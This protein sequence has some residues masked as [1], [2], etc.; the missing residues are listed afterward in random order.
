MGLRI[1]EFFGYAQRDQSATALE[2]R[3][4]FRCPFSG[5]RCRKTLDQGRLISGVCTVKQ[6]TRADP[7]ICCPI[8]LYD[9]LRQI[10]VDV[11]TQVFGPGVRVVSPDELATVPIDAT[12][13]IAFGKGSGGEL[14]LPRVE[15]RGG[16]FVDWVLA[17]VD[18]ERRLK[19]FVVVEVQSI[20][21]TGNYRAER[22]AY[23]SNEDYPEHSR[24]L[25]S[26]WENVS[27]RIIPQLVYGTRASARTTVQR[28]NVLHLHYSG[29][30]AHSGKAW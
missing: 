18:Q 9:R 22:S 27:K 6:S 21:T 3:T 12:T 7:I 11:A 1:V 8:R 23:L 4:S 5:E 17:S 28:R 15:G 26:T 16:F 30:R 25:A 10:L 13:V 29:C 14:H 19:E 2:H 20:D 24:A